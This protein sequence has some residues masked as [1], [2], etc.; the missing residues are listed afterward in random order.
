M[1]ASIFLVVSTLAAQ[2]CFGQRN[3]PHTLFLDGVERDYI[4][5]LPKGYN[6]NRKLPVV[7]IFHG[8]GGT[9][10][11]MQGYMKMD[12]IADRDSFITVYP[13]GLNKQWNDGREFKASVG[14][15]DDVRFIDQLLDTLINYYAVDT[16]RIF[17]TGISNGGFFSIYLSYKLANRLLA[18]APV[19]ASIPERIFNEFN[20]SRPVSIMIMNGT[21]DPLVPYNGGSVGNKLTGSRGNCTS[22]DKTVE[23]YVAI[24]NTNTTPVKEAIP[25]NNKR[26]DCIA[27][28][29]SYNS[30]N[31]NSTVILV[32][33]TG[34]GHTLPGGI[35]YL[36]K[37]IVGKVCKDFEGN[38]MIW[39]FFKGCI[40]K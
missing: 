35:Q 32:K 31:N 23:R 9:D 33:I 36:P 22:T 1:R 6:D 14:A 30:R 34:G 10:K 7:L 18:V 19:C 27:T 11:Q 39:E 38:E 4:V 5:H 12:P 8:G 25:D 21:E 16:N 15:N 29:Y 17:A 20:P 40:R 26:D 3:L 28:K 37:F 2:L 24:N 13:K